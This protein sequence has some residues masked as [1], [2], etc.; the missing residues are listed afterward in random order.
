MLLEHHKFSKVGRNTL[1]KH[2]FP[3][4]IKGDSNI[5]DIFIKYSLKNAE[6]AM[7]MHIT[8]L[9]LEKILQSR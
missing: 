9:S 3:R 4:D 2:K 5:L 1:L 6:F 7:D 8:S